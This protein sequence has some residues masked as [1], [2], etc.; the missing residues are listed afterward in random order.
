M[1]ALQEAGSGS[2]LQQKTI[3]GSKL[4]IITTAQIRYEGILHQADP[5]TKAMTLMQVKNFGSEG[6]RGGTQEIDSQDNVI[7]EVIFKLE[8]IRDFKIIAPPNPTLLDPAIVSASN[9]CDGSQRFS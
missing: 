9:K 7:D 1:Q 6:R 4:S 3:I 5:I 2:A 8:H